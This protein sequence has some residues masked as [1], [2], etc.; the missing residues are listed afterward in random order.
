MIDGRR[1]K[2]WASRKV[3]K[4]IKAKPLGKKTSKTQEMMRDCNLEFTFFGTSS[5]DDVLTC[6]SYRSRSN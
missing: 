1:L 3:D 5:R 2:G 6:I 4:Y